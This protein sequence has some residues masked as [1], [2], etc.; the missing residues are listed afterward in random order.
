[1]QLEQIETNKLNLMF[2]LVHADLLLLLRNFKDP[3]TAN[4]F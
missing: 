3:M 1:M 2:R 4:A